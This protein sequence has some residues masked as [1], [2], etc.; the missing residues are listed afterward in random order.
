MRIREV[1]GVQEFLGVAGVQE[2]LELQTLVFSH[3][4]GGHVVGKMYRL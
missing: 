1:L 3:L 2:L 4:I